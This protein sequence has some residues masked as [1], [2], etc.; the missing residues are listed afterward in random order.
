M[1]SRVA[2][3]LLCVVMSGC[4]GLVSESD[5]GLALPDAS[6]VTDASVEVDAGAPDAGAPDAGPPCSVGNWCEDFETGGDAGWTSRV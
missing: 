4:T 6:E 1:P 2:A 5:A 3:S